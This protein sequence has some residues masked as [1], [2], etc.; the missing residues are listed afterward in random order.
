MDIAKDTSRFKVVVTGRRWGKSVL[1]REVALHQAFN[2]P[3]SLTW[4]VTP[5]RE[6]GKD[7]HWTQLK[8]RCEDLNWNYKVNETELSITNTDNNAKIFIKTA[9]K[10]DRLRG[11]G[12][13]L[14]IPDEFAS[15][16]QSVWSEILRPALSDKKGKALFISTPAGHDVLYELYNI[17]GQKKSS[18]IS[19]NGKIIIPDSGVFILKIKLAGGYSIHRILRL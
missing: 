11:R 13:D 3:N 2:Y 14:V 16:D 18:G 6:M 9:D 8:K 10:P 5:T 19:I 7:I 1:G 17:H 12:L 15:M 4:I